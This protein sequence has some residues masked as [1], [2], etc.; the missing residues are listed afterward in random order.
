MTTP[1]TSTAPIRNAVDATTHA[2][3]YPWYAEL[4]RNAPLFFDPTL[5]LWIASSAA[6]VSAVLAHVDCRVRPAHEP[7]P[8]GLVGGA[9]GEVFRQLVR[10][11]DGT[12][13]DEPK[14]VL[15][16]ALGDVDLVRLGQR[17]AALARDDGPFRAPAPPW[18]DALNETLFRLPLYAV[19]DLLGFMPQ[20]LPQLA[21]WMRDFV[22]CLSPLSTP[23]Q[24]GAAH[25]AAAALLRR[26]ED[27]LANSVRSRGATDCTSLVSRV[28]AHAAQ[29]GWADRQALL[30]NL[31]GLLS[32][33]FDAT[34]GLLGNAVVA[35]ATRPD[36][37]AELPA[38]PQ[39]RRDTARLLVEEVCRLDPPIQNTRRFVARD[40]ELAGRLLRAGD[41]V[42]LL[43]GS[44]NRD[45]ALNARADEFLL[46]RAQRKYFSFGRGSHACPGQQI[47]LTIAASALASWLPAT[48][49]P[50]PQPTHLQA[51]TWTYRPS[52]NARIP[53][54]DLATST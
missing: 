26:F 25:E 3:P 22:A 24:L 44:A 49:S 4:R 18:A 5:K 38:H 20:D 15:E 34:A 31:I 12:R 45:A 33:T 29:T 41:T 10:M 6:A 52:V 43:L 16:R 11:N 36:L 7:V 32:Q 37:L 1:K 39:A 40:M 47:A 42:L 51:L 48:P 21:T 46:Q 35:L 50:L 27:L 28:Q 53:C 23:V 17:V 14:L 9:A 19:A 30:C 8:P 54:F 2:D 13:H